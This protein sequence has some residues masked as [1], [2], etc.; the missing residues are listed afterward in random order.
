MDDDQLKNG[1]A[2]LLDPFGD[3]IAE[4][5]ELAEGMAVAV[6]SRKKLEGARGARYRKARRPELYRHIIGKEHDSKLAVAWM[7]K[8]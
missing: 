8:E 2:M 5:S 1:C 3:L 4:C 6:C 7:S